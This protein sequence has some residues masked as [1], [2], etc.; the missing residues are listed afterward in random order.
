MG[1]VRTL[2]QPARAQCFRLSESFFSFLLFSM[3]HF[4]V[5]SCR[6]STFFLHFS[7][8]T[9]NIIPFLAFHMYVYLPKCSNVSYFYMGRDNNATVHDVV[10][11]LKK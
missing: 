6:Q 4:A 5:I 9:L 1:G 7:L 11:T 10:I 8:Y 3:C 2:L